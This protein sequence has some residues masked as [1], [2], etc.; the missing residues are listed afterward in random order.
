MTYQR[1]IG[2]YTIN[3]GHGSCKWKS[4]YC[5]IHCYNKKLYRVFGHTM[6]PKDVKNDLDWVA[7]NGDRLYEELN[8]RKYNK[9][10]RLCSRGE[11]FS[12]MADVTKI[13]DFLNKN[14]QTLF[15]IPTRS[16][17]GNLRDEVKKIMQIDNARILASIDPSNTKIEIDDIVSEG[18]STM[19][20]GDNSDI[21]NRFLCPKTWEH[22]KKICYQCEA[23]CFAKT[24][25]DVHLKK[26]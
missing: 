13:K 17:R 3:R 9:R 24:R 11:P 16:W 4:A 1:D 20:F 7:W 10:I 5:L 8:R 18:W 15:W 14:P 2:M 22:K 26:H 6:L 21:Q 12:T 19:Y 25:V 23:G